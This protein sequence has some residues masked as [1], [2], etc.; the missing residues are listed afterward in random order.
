MTGS[1]SI[2]GLFND[3]VWVK[4]AKELGNYEAQ[5]SSSSASPSALFGT[6]AP[7]SDKFE[8]IRELEEG[9]QVQDGKI[10]R[11]ELEKKKLPS[12][13]QD[14]QPSVVKQLRTI[15][16]RT[17]LTLL[18][19]TGIHFSLGLLNESELLLELFAHALQETLTSS[20]P[21]VTK[22]IQSLRGGVILLVELAKAAL[23]IALLW[24]NG[25][26]LLTNMAV[27]AREEI[28]A[29]ANS[30]ADRRFSGDEE[31]EEDEEAE[32]A[33]PMPSM[34]N[35]PGQGYR[36]Y[37]LDHIAQLKAKRTPSTPTMTS[38]VGEL[39]WIIRPVVYVLLRLSYGNSWAPWMIS[40][41]VDVCSHRLSQRSNLSGAESDELS[42]RRQLLLLYLFRS[43]F[44]QLLQQLL[45]P[46]TDFTYNAIGRLPGLQSIWDFFAE[47]LYV[48]RTR[49]FYLAGSGSP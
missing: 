35:L 8:R 20:S 40:L 14:L 5:S 16:Q 12:W 34:P 9:E 39:F 19:N 36:R 38:I 48:Y 26:R 32:S 46:A 31:D 22:V 2:F 41:L 42:R 44:F 28:I 15:F 10:P 3:A 37:T 47:L 11:E 13:A 25:G 27:P 24:R 6:P 23:R 4:K 21:R 1:V 29:L 33:F 49:Y 17:P 30:R 43:P 45:S 18:K 7:E